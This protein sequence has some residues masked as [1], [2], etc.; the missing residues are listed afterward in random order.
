MIELYDYRT[1]DV[2]NY[3]IDKV[4]SDFGITKVKAKKLLLNALTYN[5]TISEIKSQIEFLIEE[6]ESSNED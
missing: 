1:S 6:T 3:L 2:I 5:I 4:S